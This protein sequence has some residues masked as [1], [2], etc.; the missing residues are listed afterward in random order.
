MRFPYH[1]LIDFSWLAAGLLVV[2]CD[3]FPNPILERA[4]GSDLRDILLFQFLIHVEIKLKSLLVIRREV[5]EGD[6][7]ATGPTD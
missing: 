6:H 7:R 1:L 5:C 4:N 2:W 3:G